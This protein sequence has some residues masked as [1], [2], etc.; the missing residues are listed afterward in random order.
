MLNPSGLCQCGCGQKTSIAPAPS[1]GY[2]KGDPRMYIRG[3]AVVGKRWTRTK[4]PDPPNPSGLCM[5]GCGEQTPLAPR[6]HRAFGI[7]E[8]EHLRYRKGH[9]SRTEIPYFK[10]RLCACGC[11][12]QTAMIRAS[13]ATKGERRGDYRTYVRGHTNRKPI[14]ITEGDYELEDRGFVTKCWIWKGSIDNKGYAIRTRSRNKQKLKTNRAHRISYEQFIG[15]IEDGKT[16]HHA[17]RQTRCIN[18]SHLEQLP[19]SDNVRHSHKH[20]LPRSLRDKIVK[21]DSNTCLTCGAT[22]NL[23]VDHIVP[24]SRGGTHH[25]S[26]L[27]TLCRRCNSRKGRFLLTPG[28]VNRS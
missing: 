27:Q 24:E 9:Q 17:C 11:G 6:T 14:A 10:P 19:N 15:P 28:G 21:R 12:E 8:G 1:P 7:V 13:D 23:T 20:R 26:N 5:C 4:L 22:K 3:H 18:P 16:I 2:A 25:E